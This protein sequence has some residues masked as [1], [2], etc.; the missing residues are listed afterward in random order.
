[1][2]RTSSNT[3]ATRI[4]DRFGS[5]IGVNEILR[6]LGEVAEQ[7]LQRE[8]RLGLVNTLRIPGF[9]NSFPLLLL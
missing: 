6:D 3:A 8:E 9:G 1:M 2:I 7:L 5:L 4:I